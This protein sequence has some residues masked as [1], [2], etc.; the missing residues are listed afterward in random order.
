MTVRPLTMLAICH[1]DV[2]RICRVGIPGA[3]EYACDMCGETGAF[4]LNPQY[5]ITTWSN[6]NEP[7][8]DAT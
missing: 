1:H 2:V 7:S 8:Q 4:V 5:T 3:V 6:H